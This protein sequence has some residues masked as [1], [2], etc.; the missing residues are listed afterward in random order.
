MNNKYHE[1]LQQFKAD[2]NAKLL[3][4]NEYSVL[5]ITRCGL[6]IQITVPK[7]VLEWFVEVFEDDAVT[8]QD[9]WDYEGYDKTPRDK[10][11]NS[12]HSDI[13]EFVTSLLTRNIRLASCNQMRL[14]KSVSKLKNLLGIPSEIRKTLEWEH[15]GAWQQALP[16]C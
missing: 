7:T 2:P 9:W 13:K 15:D 12:M 10:L 8:V 4:F 1:I 6:T 14:E 5:E 16:F 11:H 3:I